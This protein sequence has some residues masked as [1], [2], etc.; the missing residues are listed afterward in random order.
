MS[1]KPT[2]INK[3]QQITQKPS[4]VSVSAHWQGPLP[5]PAVLR[6]FDNALPGTAERIVC[7]AESE[8]AHRQAHENQVL[9]N[10]ANDTKRGHYIGLAIT[11]MCIAAAVYCVWLGLDWKFAGVFIGLPLVVIVQSFLGAKTR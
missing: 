1:T 11:T 2:K 6:E 9:S 3:P 5:P 7:M 8:V 10:I 4:G